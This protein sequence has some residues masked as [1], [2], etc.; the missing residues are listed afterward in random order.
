MNYDY[1]ECGDC[2]ELMKQIPDGS[3][4]LVVTDPPYGTMDTDGGRKIGIHGWDKQIPT[5]PMFAELSRILRPNGKLVLF[6]QEPYTSK[7][8]TSA[9][10]SL[11]CSY[12]AIWK[13]D[14]FGNCLGAN[15]NMVSYFEDILIFSK[16]HP[17]H[18]FKGVH[19]LRPYFAKILDFVGFASCK[20]VNNA[21]G[22]RRAEH[23][24]YI[25]STQFSLCTEKT[26]RELIDKFHIDEMTGFVQFEEL[27]KID[28]EY[29][30]DLINRMNS[31]YPGIFNLWEGGKSKSNVLEYPKDMDGF[32]PTQKPVALLEDLIK[33]FSNPGDVVLDFTMGSGSTCVA[34]VNTGRHYIGFEKEPKYFDI[35]CQRLDEAEEA[36]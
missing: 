9:V 24:F 17:K 27:Q 16:V 14:S 6:S 8:I 15:K 5:V 12:R 26:Y 2:L 1:I 30:T 23:T 4:D 29:R 32:H 18:D 21:L 31:Q 34:C 19:P 7:L 28:T 35:A 36:L 13:K 11:P 33:T 10:S 3:V 25:N 20:D 22:H